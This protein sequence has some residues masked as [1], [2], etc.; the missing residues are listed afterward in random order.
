MH[1]YIFSPAFLFCSDSSHLMRFQKAAALDAEEFSGINDEE[2]L[3]AVLEMSRREAELPGAAPLEDEPTS[4]PDTGFGDSD[5]HEVAYHADMLETD[6][7]PPA[8]TGNCL[9]PERTES[10]I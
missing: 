6:N 1:L 9:K 5:V 10:N 4:S 7:K 3:A 8:G 2:M